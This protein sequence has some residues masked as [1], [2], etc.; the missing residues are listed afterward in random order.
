MERPFREVHELYRI[1]FLRAQAEKEADEKR[2]AEEEKRA[3]EERK[4]GNKKP[5][6]NRQP[7]DLSIPSPSP[8]Q[9]EAL[10]DAFE[11]LAEGGGF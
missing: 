10:E 4:N 9:A 5:Q 7:T 8:M 1:L 11:E 6:Y 2:K 3:R